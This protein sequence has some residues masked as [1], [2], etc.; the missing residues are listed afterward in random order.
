MTIGA[1]RASV[2]W[3]ALRR[4][5]HTPSPQVGLPHLYCRES[6]HCDGLEKPEAIGPKVADLAKR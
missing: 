1:L 3:S 6:E 4:L 2:M 5:V